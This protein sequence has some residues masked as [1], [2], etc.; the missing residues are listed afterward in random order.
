MDPS[1]EQVALRENV[2]IFLEEFGDS[3]DEVGAY[4]GAMGVYVGRTSTGDSPAARYLQAV[5]GADPRVT[6]V[7]VNNRRVALKTRKRGWWSTAL[8][9]QTVRVRLPRPVRQFVS[10]VD[11]RPAP[12]VT[13]VP[14]ERH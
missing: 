6:R 7:R 14:F 9:P 8:V 2:A 11:W 5:L 10:S 1:A 3:P 13:E 12:G 4:L